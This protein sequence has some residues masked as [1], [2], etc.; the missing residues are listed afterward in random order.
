MHWHTYCIPHSM[1]RPCPRCKL[2]K[3]SAHFV[4]RVSLCI[5][6]YSSIPANR[7][8]TMAQLAVKMK[9]ARINRSLENAARRAA[10]DR[11]LAEMFGNGRDE[12]VSV[13]EILNITRRKG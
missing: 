3:P 12:T 6:C 9:R 5:T 10:I 1:P 7:G 8:L 4:G 13:N 2:T 11:E